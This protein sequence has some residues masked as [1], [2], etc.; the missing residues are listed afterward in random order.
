MPLEELET[1]LSSLQFLLASCKQIRI[2]RLPNYFNPG[3]ANV[4][5]QEW[6]T[7]GTKTRNLDDLPREIRDRIYEF[8]LRAKDPPPKSPP[9]LGDWQ[10][11]SWYHVRLPVHLPK[12]S[13]IGLLLSCRQFHD[14]LKATIQRIGLV[15]E[16][17]TLDWNG[18]GFCPIWTLTPCRSAHVNHVNL[19]FVHHREEISTPNEFTIP[20]PRQRE[21]EELEKKMKDIQLLACCSGRWRRQYLELGDRLWGLRYLDDHSENGYDHPRTISSYLSF[22]TLKLLGSGAC[23]TFQCRRRCKPKGGSPYSIGTLHIEG[24]LSGGWLRMSPNPEYDKQKRPPSPSSL[25]PSVAGVDVPDLLSNFL[26]CGL[27][28]FSPSLKNDARTLCER[29]N[30]VEVSFN[31]ATAREWDLQTLKESFQ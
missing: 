30:R 7:I 26:I 24:Q 23:L 5:F 2:D 13:A 10:E 29:V 8:L 15:Y 18:N 16:L 22:I 9:K 27:P 25:R 6:P 21:I 4:V 19:K 20:P 1:D 31:G 17:T 14:E 12:A 3:L 28:C 11:G